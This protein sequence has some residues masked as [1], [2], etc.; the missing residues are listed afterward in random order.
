MKLRQM[1]RI[2]IYPVSFFYR[3]TI[4][5]LSNEILKVQTESVN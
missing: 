5:S 1:I 2:S 3:L 4:A